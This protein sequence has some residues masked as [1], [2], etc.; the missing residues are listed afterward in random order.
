MVP[1]LSLPDDLARRSV[2]SPGLRR[3]VALLLILVI[4]SLDYIAPPDVAT[5]AF[6]IPILFILAL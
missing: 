3:I 5:D 6:Y 2:L 1:H 4:G